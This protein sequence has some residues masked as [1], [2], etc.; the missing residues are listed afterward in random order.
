MTPKQEALYELNL[1]YAALDYPLVSDKKAEKM[2][3]G[4]V[5]LNIEAARKEL[6]TA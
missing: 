6:A 4:V 3:I 1:L 5:K 2:S